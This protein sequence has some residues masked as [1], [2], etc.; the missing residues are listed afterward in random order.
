M[1]KNDNIVLK[2]GD[3]VRTRDIRLVRLYVADGLPDRVIIHT[4]FNDMFRIDFDDAFPA[5]AYRD[6]L[7][8][9]IM[10]RSKKSSFIERLKS[11]Y[12][13]KRTLGKHTYLSFI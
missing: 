6:E 10:H 2:T 11:W 7:V 9:A 1:N 12:A 4:T 8:A 3:M 5:Q 13:Q